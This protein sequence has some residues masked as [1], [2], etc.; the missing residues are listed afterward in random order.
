RVSEAVTSLCA[1]STC[2]IG[3]DEGLV[4]VVRGL[5]DEATDV[6][7]DRVALGEPREGLRDDFEQERESSPQQEVGV[8]GEGVLRRPEA[9]P[10]FLKRVEPVDE[11]T[12]WFLHL[13]LPHGP[14]RLYPGGSP[15]DP[16]NWMDPESYPTDHSNESGPWIAAVAEQRHLLQLEYADALVGQVLDRLKDTG[17]Y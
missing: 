1:P 7:R 17:E 10:E 2:R 8:D 13:V 11:P 12:L 5:V 4:S 16:G 9:Q 14:W 6:W 15:Y 3:G